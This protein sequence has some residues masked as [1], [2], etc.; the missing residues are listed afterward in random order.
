MSLKH[1]LKLILNAQGR[2]TFKTPEYYLP[3]PDMR[4]GK[5]NTKTNDD[6]K[7]RTSFKNETHKTPAKKSKSL[8]LK[9]QNSNQANL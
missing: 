1:S 9:F 2:L 4:Y 8:R 3:K 5:E 6:R 7:R